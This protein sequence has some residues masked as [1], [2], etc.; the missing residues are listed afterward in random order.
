MYNDVVDQVLLKIIIN[1]SNIEILFNNCK[2]NKDI[3][4]V[5]RENRE[6]IGEELLKKRGYQNGNYARLKR[7][8]KLDSS[9]ETNIRNIVILYNNNDDD[10]LEMILDIYYGNIFELTEQYNIPELANIILDV[11]H[12]KNK[13]NFGNLLFMKLIQWNLFENKVIPDK[14]TFE[15]LMKEHNSIFNTKYNL[16]EYI[17]LFKSQITSKIDFTNI[18]NLETKLSAMLQKWD[19]W[20]ENPSKF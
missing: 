13:S 8:F 4:R 5:C 19:Y 10:L 11:I 9:L 18:T 2:S 14:Q 7:F 15:K 20:M 17:D 1:T 12:N 16:N 6:L 3:N